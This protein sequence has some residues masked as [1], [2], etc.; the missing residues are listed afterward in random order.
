VARDLGR[1][2]QRRGEGVEGLGEH[3]VGWVGFVLKRDL[4]LLV[5][6]GKKN[7]RLPELFG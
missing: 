6:G 7:E 4:S 2:Q 3:V 5:S 1:C